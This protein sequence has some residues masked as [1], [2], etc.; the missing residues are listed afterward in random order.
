MSVFNL[1]KVRREKPTSR[2]FQFGN[3]EDQLTSVVKFENPMF[4]MQS[5]NW[6]EGLT[7]DLLSEITVRMN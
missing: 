4:P 2:A 3:D 1:Y 7:I 5:T 6:V